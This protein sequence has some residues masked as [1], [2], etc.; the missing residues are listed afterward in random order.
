MNRE[1]RAKV[2]H[3]LTTAI[4]LYNDLKQEQAEIE[5]LD[6]F[7]RKETNP[8]PPKMSDLSWSTCW[9]AP[10]VAIII[11]GVASGINNIIGGI[12]GLIALIIALGAVVVTVVSKITD[13][14]HMRRYRKEEATYFPKHWER[15]RSTPEWNR[16]NELGND[17]VAKQ[18]SLTSIC[19][20]MYIPKHFVDDHH[21][22][23]L[24]TYLDQEA[25]NA[26]TYRAWLRGAFEKLERADQ[27]L[28]E[29]HRRAKEIIDSMLAGSD[30]PSSSSVSDPPSIPYCNGSAIAGDSIWYDY[31]TGEKLKVTYDGRTVNSEGEEVSSAWW[32]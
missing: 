3:K 16:R 22:T 30:E 27:E 21:L 11:G 23:M 7:I 5:K 13:G 28:E 8:E 17:V 4:A 26:E 10:L 32:D 25:D 14:V 31:R 29:N 2:S 1:E 24:R 19:D 6:Q 12:V 15:V 9:I 18:A 20:E